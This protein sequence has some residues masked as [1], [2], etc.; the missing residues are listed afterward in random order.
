VAFFFFIILYLVHFPLH[1]DNSN[2]TTPETPPEKPPRCSSSKTSSGTIQRS[3]WRKPKTWSSASSIK[4][5]HG[6]TNVRPGEAKWYL[7]AVSS[8]NSNNT[9][10]PTPIIDQPTGKLGK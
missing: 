5:K 6:K 1:S 2:T 8:I 3:R 7:E 10:I 9:T 4:R